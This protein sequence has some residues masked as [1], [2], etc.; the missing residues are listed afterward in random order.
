MFG[1]FCRLL[2]VSLSVFCCFVSVFLVGFCRFVVVLLKLNVV[3]SLSLMVLLVSS[4]VFFEKLVVDILEAVLMT[5]P[6]A[7]LVGLLQVSHV[8]MHP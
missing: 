5:F 8:P 6:V 7:M 2:N 1:C 4:S 3:S